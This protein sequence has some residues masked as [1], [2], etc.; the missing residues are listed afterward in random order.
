MSS[1]SAK[2]AGGVLAALIL[3]AVGVGACTDDNDEIREAVDVVFRYDNWGHTESKHE[4]DVELRFTNMETD[5]RMTWRGGA[6]D[7]LRLLEYLDKGR[8]YLHPLARE[9]AEM[10]PCG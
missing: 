8:C 4:D 6:R 9:L 3:G 5:K 7:A 1:A 10:V 2:A